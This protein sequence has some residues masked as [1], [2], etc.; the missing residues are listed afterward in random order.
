[1]RLSAK[2]TAGGDIVV[3]DADRTSV[4][5]FLTDDSMANAD[6]LRDVN[7]AMRKGL[8]VRVVLIACRT[9]SREVACELNER[10]PIKGAC[11]VVDDGGA[12]C[13]QLKV[14][15]W[16]TI[17]LVR[18]DGTLIARLG[19][20]AEVLAMKLSQYLVASSDAAAVQTVT[21]G[22]RAQAHRDLQVARDLV[23]RGKASEAMTN[24]P[25][26]RCRQA[27]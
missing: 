5:L 11:V 4:V 2:D 26:M 20:S 27:S 21:D 7:V 10:A 6:L 9:R 19:G 18:S 8:D 24:C 16:P 3:P 1:V 22:P 13:E 14:R 17:L 12:V 23:R 15:A 25:P